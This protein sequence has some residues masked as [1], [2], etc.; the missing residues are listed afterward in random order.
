MSQISTRQVLFR[1]Q[2]KELEYHKAPVDVI[3]NR[4]SIGSALT[5]L[6]PPMKYIIR[7]FFK[8]L[9]ALLGPLLLAWE[10]LSRPRG[11]VRTP[12]LQASVDEQCHSLALY[13]YKTCPFCMKVRQ[14][15]RRLSL[16]IAKCDAQHNLSNREEL[17]KGGGKVKV[18]CLKITDQAG[19]TKWIYES[20]AIIAYLKAR[21]EPA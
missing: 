15:M 4:T 7:T 14:E 19:Q 16:A 3:D 21:F 2:L 12:S 11:L 9:R 1:P 8:T 13:Q 10:Q 5:S 18:P 6:S 20:E 17:L